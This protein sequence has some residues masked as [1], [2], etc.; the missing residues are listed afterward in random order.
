MVEIIATEKNKDQR[1]EITEESLRD[2]W[3]NIKHTNICIIG[4]PEE[5]KEKEKVKEKIFRDFS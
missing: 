2:L 5:E 1:M 4:V 3:D